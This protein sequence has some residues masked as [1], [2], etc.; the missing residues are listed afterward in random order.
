MGNYIRNLQAAIKQRWPDAIII[1]FGHL[2][3]GNLH[4]FIHIGPQLSASDKA[5]INPLV[6]QPLADIEGSIFAE[7]GIG[8]QKKSYLTYSR[9]K[10]E[11]QI[12]RDLKRVLDPLNILNPGAIFDS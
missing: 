2:G 6:Y 4:L 8:F 9:S 7:H 12:M 10:D 1:L 3:D 5:D 11:I